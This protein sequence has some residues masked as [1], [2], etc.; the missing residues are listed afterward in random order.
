MRKTFRYRIYPTKAQATKLIHALDQCR[1]LYNNTLAYRRDAWETEQRNAGWYETK[2]RIPLLKAERPALATVHSQVLQNVTERLE[3]AFQAFFRRV[4]AGEEPGYPRLR[5]VGRYSSLTYPQYGNGAT[6]TDDRLYLSKIGHV[7]IVLHRPLEGTPKTVTITHSSSGNWYVA[8]SCEWEPTPLPETEPVVGIDVGLHSFA[9]LSD[10]TA[11]E[12]PRFF[13]SEERA[14]AKVQRAHSKLDKGTPRRRKHRKAVARVHERIAWRRQNHAH[15]HSRLIV[16]AH[17]VI[18]VED[19]AVNRLVHNHCLAKSIS[20]AAWAEFA[21]FL[22][23][24][25]AW[26]GRQ[27]VAVNPA[28]TSQDCHGCGHRQKMPLADRVYRCPCCGGAW[29]RDHNAALNILAR[30]LTSIRT[31]SVEAPGFIRGE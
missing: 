29:D 2:R 11:I 20:D 10:G 13:R 24:K 21:T 19:L 18:A 23:Y 12:N 14:L 3:L 9:T 17:Q 5:G 15:Q 25:A 31:Q 26:A 27:Y 8:F 30:G 28:Y 16:N 1:W 4:K 6:L 22:A 7:A